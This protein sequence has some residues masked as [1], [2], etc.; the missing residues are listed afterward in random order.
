M[1]FW[2]IRR[3]NSAVGVEMM[4]NEPDFRSASRASKRLFFDQKDCDLVAANPAGFSALD[5]RVVAFSAYEEAS[6]A[7]RDAVVLLLPPEVATAFSGRRLIYVAEEDERAREKNSDSPKPINGRFSGHLFR[8]S[9]E[10][11]LEK[12][13]RDRKWQPEEIP[14]PVSFETRRLP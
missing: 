10:A 4:E 9:S 12:P 7:L 13:L 3:R 5:Y 11:S 6:L 2:A 1:I 14:A 8:G